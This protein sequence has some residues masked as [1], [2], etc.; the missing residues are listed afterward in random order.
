MNKFFNKNI[1]IPNGFSCNYN[2]MYNYYISDAN[3][4]KDIL[5]TISKKKINQKLNHYS[6]L[7][8]DKCNQL[9]LFFTKNNGIDSIESQNELKKYHKEVCNILRGNLPYDY[10]YVTNKDGLT[11]YSPR[12]PINGFRNNSKTLINYKKKIEKQKDEVIHKTDYEKFCDIN[13][14]R[15]VSELLDYD[16]NIDKFDLLLEKRLKSLWKAYNN[17]ICI[18]LD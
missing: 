11:T 1:D 15:I 8:N 3:T 10:Y 6:D 14:P 16:I 2:Q 13:K 5:K 18:D 12:L 4:R 7:L 9:M 17:P